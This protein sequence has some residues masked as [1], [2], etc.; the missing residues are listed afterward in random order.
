[1]KE[2]RVLISKEKNKVCAHPEVL[3][4]L[5]YSIKLM[6]RTIPKIYPLPHLP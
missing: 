6:L 5:R 4:P 1:M 3:L 2:N